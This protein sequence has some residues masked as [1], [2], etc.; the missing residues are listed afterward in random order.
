MSRRLIVRYEAE[1]DITE[2]AL[3]YEQQEAGL[4]LE[5]TLE[6]RAAIKRAVERPLLPC[7]C[8]GVLKSGAFSRGVFP[9]A[10]SSSSE[11]MPS[12]FLLFSMPPVTTVVG[13]NAYKSLRPNCRCFQRSWVEP[14]GKPTLRFGREILDSTP[15]YEPDATGVQRMMRQDQPPSLFLRQPVFNEGQIQVFIAP[16][17]FVPHD[18]MAE[19]GQVDSD[20]VLSPCLWPDKQHREHF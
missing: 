4:G 13:V 19:M 8:G 12:S 1:A 5:L 7:F 2:A 15:P 6:V 17:N 20:L 16:V 18:R 11:T 10:S 3:W 9:I 14:L